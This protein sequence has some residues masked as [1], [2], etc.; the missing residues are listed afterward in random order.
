MLKPRKYNYPKHQHSQVQDVVL[1]RQEE[2]LDIKRRRSHGAQRKN[3]NSGF[4]V[5]RPVSLMRRS[6]HRRQDV[7]K[8]LKIAVYLQRRLAPTHYDVARRPLRRET[9][10]AR[11]ASRSWQLALQLPPKRLGAPFDDGVPR[12]YSGQFLLIRTLCCP[13]Q[14]FLP[15]PL[16]YFMASP[17]LLLCH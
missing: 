2:R 16:S 14:N 13:E 15:E 4:D 17:A 7:K 3:G 8:S 5:L 12:P 10:H 6:R 1:F 9:S 11:P